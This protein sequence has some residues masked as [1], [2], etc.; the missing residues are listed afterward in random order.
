MLLIE[1]YVS[2][3]K[4]LTIKNNPEVVEIIQPLFTKDDLD[5]VIYRVRFKLE[6]NE[7][8]NDPLLMI[9]KNIH[10]EYNDIVIV[11]LSSTQN[12]FVN[13]IMYEIED[14][15]RDIIIPLINCQ[16][17][18]LTIRDIKTEFNIF[19][20]IVIT[21]NK[22]KKE[23]IRNY[24]FQNTH[25]M[26]FYDGFIRKVEKINSE[27]QFDQKVK[28]IEKIEHT[29]CYLCGYLMSK[30]LCF[31]N[32]E[33]VVF[34]KNENLFQMFREWF[35]KMIDH[36]IKYCQNCQKMYFEKIL[37]R[38]CRECKVEGKIDNLEKNNLEIGKVEVEVE[39]KIIDL[40][41]NEDY[42]EVNKIDEKEFELQEL[43]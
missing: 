34:E 21:L 17:V 39:N 25:D 13:D 32:N 26:L 23:E 29:Y 8:Q 24:N 43:K 5:G 11:K 7:N 36:E 16:W 20:Y 15:K 12:L 31:K 42:K 4:T 2:E 14:T 1:K 40:D 33:I 41:E 22:D 27:N 3:L 30:C 19:E 6:K 37:C 9:T 10:R 28:Q 35:G 38:E 18:N